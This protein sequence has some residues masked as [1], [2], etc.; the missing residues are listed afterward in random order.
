MAVSDNSEKVGLIFLPHT[1][2]INL[3]SITEVNLILWMWITV[4]IP[5][6]IP[7]SGVEV[8]ITS[9]V[10]F[11]V[12]CVICILLSLS[13]K[14]GFEWHSLF[15]V[16]PQWQ[17]WDSIWDSSEA[18][19]KQTVI[20][21]IPWSVCERPGKPWLSHL[22]TTTTLVKSCGTL[23]LVWSIFTLS[24]FQSA[25]WVI[26]N[27]NKLLLT[28]KG[29]FV[30]RCQFDE[31]VCTGSYVK[32]GH[33]CHARIV[34]IRPLF[35]FWPECTIK[36]M[37]LSYNSIQLVTCTLVFASPN[38]MYMKLPTWRVSSVHLKPQG[39]DFKMW[40]FTRT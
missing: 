25:L 7:C 16:Y 40:L 28:G 12:V 17:N 26:C 22:S 39:S 4:H 11:C 15:N 32:K 10:Y 33:V 2:Q 29:G 8:Q 35:Y 1:N 21:N 31:T 30:S 5:I 18:K 24:T 9:S 6:H 27:S 19:G 14:F 38:V 3:F 37:N 23:G 13:F 20:W 34:V 36:Y